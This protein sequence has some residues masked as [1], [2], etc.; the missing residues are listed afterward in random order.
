MPTL[1]VS[2]SRLPS[3]VL[4]RPRLLQQLEAADSRFL[5]LIAPAGYGKTTLM[6]QF[7]QRFSGTVVW[8][9]L[10]DVSADSL[11]LAQ[12]LVAALQLI[13]PRAKFA[14]WQEALAAGVLPARLAVALA[15]DINRLRKPVLLVLDRAERLSAESGRWLETLF[16]ALELRHRVLWAGF[17]GSPLPIARFVAD[18]KATLF[19][20]T[21]LLFTTQEARAY[22]QMRGFS[23]DASLAA[24]ALEGW[25]VGLALL[26]SGSGLA[27]RSDQLIFEVLERLP[28][29]E[30]IAELAVLE[31]WD[32]RGAAQLGCVLPQ[33]WLQTVVNAGLPLQVLGVN[34]YSPHSVLLEA[35]EVWLQRSPVRHAELHG[36]AASLAE[37]SGLLLEA[38]R[39]FRMARTLPEVHRIAEL[40]VVP[41][42]NREE[43]RWIR[44]LLESFEP[45]ELSTR[46]QLRLVQALRQTGDLPRADELLQQV[47]DSGAEDSLL[48]ALMAIGEY[49]QGNF[50]RQLEFVHQGLT[51]ESDVR[52]RAKL[53]MTLAAGLSELGRLEE[54]VLA[55]EEAVHCAELSGDQMLIAAT[56]SVLAASYGSV[57]R[58]VDCERMFKRSL[59]LCKKLDVPAKALASYNNFANYLSDWGRLSE[60][61]EMTQKG[62]PLAR[63][64]QSFWLALLLGT[65]GILH[66][67]MGNFLAALQSFSEGIERC[68][69][70]GLG[71]TDYNYRLFAIQAAILASDLGKA[72]NLLLEAQISRPTEALVQLNRLYFVQ[73]MF[74]FASADFVGAKNW[75]VQV[76]G[77]FDDF[78]QPRLQAYL[79]EIARREGCLTRVMVTALVESLERLGHR[80]SLNL[81]PHFLIGLYQECVRRGWY[82]EVFQQFVVSTTKDGVEF[83]VDLWEKPIF[84]IS[85]TVAKIPLAKSRELLAW[86]VIN[87]A[88]TRNELILALWG[89]TNE[90]RNLEYFKI[91]LRKLRTALLSNSSITFDPILFETGLYK[92]HPRLNIVCSAKNILKAGERFPT[93]IPRLEA[94]FSS[95][96]GLFMLG[97][98]SAW[99]LELR[100]ML[101]DITVRIGKQLGLLL[102]E[103]DQF[104]AARVLRRVR[105]FDPLFGVA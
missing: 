56:V 83:E 48:F 12:S 45:A 95:Y 22:L 47:R 98:D 65:E 30:T 99:I 46:L 59:E 79:A 43:F 8:V 18:G 69:F 58:R 33:G 5:A 37:R 50:E 49:N 23:G 82:P 89:D 32:E 105:E 9:S 72:K 88:S 104:K 52:M 80:F 90:K 51:L 25:A 2:R 21:D 44:H 36:A 7:A 42:V 57:G 96:R 60:A 75:F 97:I 15:L 29:R 39:H 64:T 19:G 92:L 34:Q 84:L 102:L 1:S 101:L 81:E 13:L 62:M 91:A 27:L 87:G 24:L 100:H 10:S 76:D 70:F 26:A 63:A 103:S 54:D 77:V 93:D 6:A 20:L 86:L 31:V 68:G 53:L 67:R 14:S 78:D 16:E 11:A 35:L 3:V 61:L 66:F 55:A 4:E 40:I 41:A 94:L 17:E 74:A 85:S 73:G 28:L 71:G 38:L